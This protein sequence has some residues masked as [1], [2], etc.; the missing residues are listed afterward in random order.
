MKLEIKNT[1]LFDDS[2]N[3][4]SSKLAGLDG[5]PGEKD[6][7]SNKKLVQIAFSNEVLKK[8]YN[9]EPIEVSTNHLVVIHLKEHQ[10]QK[11]KELAVV[12]DDIKFVLKKDIASDLAVASGEKIVKLL[13]DGGDIATEIKTLG[14]AWQEKKFIKGSMENG[15]EKNIAQK[16]WQ[17]ILP[18]A[19]YGF[20]RS[21]ATAYAMIAYQ[22]AYLKTHFPVEFMAALLTSEKTDIERIAILIEECKKMGIEVLPPNINESLKNFTVAPKKNKIRF[23]LLA[24]KNVGENVIEAIVE[25]VKKNGLFKSIEDFAQR[26]SSKNLLNVGMTAGMRLPI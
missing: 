2:G 17:W 22:T 6:I 13:K 20:N 10:K 25:E 7:T 15:I 24:I 8:N 11:Q 26:I 21:H 9:S 5:R 19:R 14:I 16:I 4:V 23:G 18:F 3:T 12:K 1:A